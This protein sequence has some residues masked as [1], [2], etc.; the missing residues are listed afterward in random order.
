VR[1]AS[2]TF[3]LR[4][5]LAS[6]TSCALN[7][8]NPR[9]VTLLSCEEATALDAMLDASGRV[10]AVPSYTDPPSAHSAARRLGLTKVKGTQIPLSRRVP[11]T[12]TVW[13]HT[14]NGCNLSCSYCYIPQLRKALTPERAM[15]YLMSDQTSSAMVS[16]LIKVC[17]REGFERLYLKFAGGEPTLNWAE[18][19][20]T[21][22]EAVRS[23]SEAGI[24]PGFQM[25]TNGVFDHTKVLPDA[26]ALKMS[27]SISVD[28]DPEVHD[29]VRFL[30]S[31]VAKAFYSD[32]EPVEA[33]R[34]R[35]RGSWAIVKANIDRLLAAGI[36]PYLLCTVDERN[37]RQFHDLVGYCAAK[38][39]GF[40][41]SPVRDTKTYK[42]PGL[43]EAIT[44][45]LIG[46]YREM[47]ENHPLDMP[48]G[49]F[50]RFAEW[51]L[52]MRKNLPCASCRAMLAVGDSGQVASCQMR[53]DHPVATLQDAAFDQVFDALRHSD[54]YKYF[55]H[56][57]AK[58]GKCAGCIFK[59]T[60]A[61][62]CPEHTRMVFGSNNHASPWCD[63]Y[64]AMMPE[65]VAAIGRQMERVQNVQGGEATAG[66]AAR[67]ASLTPQWYID[68][69]GRHEYRYWNGT[70]WTDYV[71]DNGETATDP[72][73]DENPSMSSTLS[74]NP[75]R[76]SG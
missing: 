6:G 47:G 58:T 68:P 49:S 71:A 21:C 63:L 7:L 74:L 5:K 55:L 42:L 24:Q 11:R 33:L 27:V 37:Y 17:Q 29:T 2:E 75:P 45:E 26:A 72:L 25:L 34:P 8:T 30:T 16:G 10:V 12:L 70:S 60:C 38:K 61:G 41:L 66:P 22:H 69:S 14:S 31:R 65:Y 62:G 44:G 56:P 4:R 39:L 52:D 53:L 73:V 46:L 40:R 51:N 35:R 57:E 1:Q 48:I 59:Y 28:G 20:R 67:S 13:V 64:T 76:K 36:R 43:Q 19:V 9:G 32:E 3:I 50:A 23:C 18:V 54:E 15:P